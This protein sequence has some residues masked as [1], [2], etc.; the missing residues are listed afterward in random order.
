MTIE[1]FLARLES[2]GLL[3]KAVRPIPRDLIEKPPPKPGKTVLEALI[4]ERRD[5]R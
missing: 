4:E 2:E 5:G 3:R 1:R